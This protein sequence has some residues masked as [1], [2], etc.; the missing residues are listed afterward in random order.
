MIVVAES[1]RGMEEQLAIVSDFFRGFGLELNVKKCKSVLLRRTRDCM[2]VDTAAKW[3][4]EDKEIPQVTPEETMKYLGVEFTPLK[5]PRVFDLEGRLRTMI[6]RIGARGIGLKPDQRVALLC[7]YAVPRLLHQLKF[8]PVSGTTLDCLDRM[9]R[10]AVKDWVKLPPSATDGVLYAANRD[11]GLAIPKL[12]S[13]LP[14]AKAKTLKRLSR[15]TFSVIPEVLAALTDEE[16]ISIWGDTRKRRGRKP[17]RTE[18]A[19]GWEWLP[20]Q[21]VGIQHFL[22]SNVSNSW[23]RRPP[24][25]K[26]S[27]WCRCLQSSFWPGNARATAGESGLNTNVGWVSLRPDLILHDGG[28]RAIVIDVA[29]TYETEDPDVFEKAYEAKANKY[30]VLRE[31]L[32]NEGLGE[33]ATF[34]GFILCSRGAFPKCNERVLV[35]V[36]IRNWHFK[37]M[38]SRRALFMSCDMLRYLED[39]PPGSWVSFYDMEANM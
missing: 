17:W 34:H 14:E 20:T 26:A 33:T 28:G 18:E 2:V 10:M 9:I 15:S 30:R 13:I 39:R 16:R 1:V 19:L 7:T 3:S 23:L 12:K 38:L 25:V 5:G 36:G 24:G 29:I 22:G 11:G 35:D 37:A 32:A 4:V 8:C 27:T 31:Y 6:E 21:G